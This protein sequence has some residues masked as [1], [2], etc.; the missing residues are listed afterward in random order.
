M[1][2]AYTERK[3]EKKKKK[4]KTTTTTTKGRVGR[5][6]MRTVVSKDSL[7]L[8]THLQRSDLGVFGKGFRY[9]YLPSYEPAVH[10]VASVPLVGQDAQPGL[11]NA[12]AASVERT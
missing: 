9:N 12:M 1:L 10:P 8:F 5:F 7:F 4:K 11:Q 3:R 6:Q 2:G